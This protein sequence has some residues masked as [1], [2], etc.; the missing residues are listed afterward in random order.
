MDKMAFSPLT[1][2]TSRSVNSSTGQSFPGNFAY[3]LTAM[4]VCSSRLNK[5]FP[6]KDDHKTVPPRVLFELLLRR[7]GG[8][9]GQ[10]LRQKILL[11]GLRQS[12][13]DILRHHEKW[14]PIHRIDPIIHRRP[15][16][17]F[18]ARDIGLGTLG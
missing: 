9:I 6:I 10:Q 2:T 15:Q 12:L 17:Q 18:F 5:S 16:T 14:P 4:R 11:E 13:I 1:K 7:L 3:V 8:N